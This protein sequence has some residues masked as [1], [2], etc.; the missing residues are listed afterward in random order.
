[1]NSS[2]ISIRQ[3]INHVTQSN[4]IVKTHID[5]NMHPTHLT[6]IAR[7]KHLFHMTRITITHGAH[8]IETKNLL[9]MQKHMQRLQSLNPF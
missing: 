3:S 1:M 4:M 8:A 2:N 5:K 9:K 7:I 6:R